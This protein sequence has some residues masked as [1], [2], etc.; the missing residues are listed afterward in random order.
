MTRRALLVAVWAVRLRADAADDVWSLIA[1]MASALVDGNVSE[2][3]S[4]FDP[5]MPGFD[6]L[7]SDVT[8]L[9]REFVA[10]S[11]IDPVKNEGDDRN[12]ALELDWRLTLVDQ[13]NDASA[14][15]REQD[16]KC[17]LV[18]T[19][20]KWRITAFEPVS[21]FAPPAARMPA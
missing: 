6:E 1:S 3:M 13:Q 7:R 17:R 20:R 16:V 4:Y 19:G 9:V 12:R 18:K 10:Q 14:T 15:N 21:L 2:F 11:S 5:A 8:A